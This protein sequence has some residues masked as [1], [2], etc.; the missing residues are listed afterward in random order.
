V[1]GVILFSDIL[2]PLPGMNVDF[3]ILETKGPVIKDVYRS[4]VRSPTT[5]SATTPQRK[6]DS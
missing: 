2:T 1:D 6:I 4:K 5:A 3:D